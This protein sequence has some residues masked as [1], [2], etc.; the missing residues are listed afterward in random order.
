[1]GFVPIIASA[2]FAGV[3]G[4]RVR[5]C[6]IGRSF[7]FRTLAA[8]FHDGRVHQRCAFDDI[9][10]GFELAVEQIQQLLVQLTLN[11]PLAKAANRCFVGYRF[12]GV[13]LDKLLKTQAVLDLCFRLRITQVVE[14]LQNHDV[15]LR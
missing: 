13:Q 5:C 1:M 2:G 6:S 10:A 9:A 14:V 3:G 4:V 7:N 15:P 11:K 8:G 12:V